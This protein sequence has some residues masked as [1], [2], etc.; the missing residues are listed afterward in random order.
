VNLIDA[1]FEAFVFVAILVI[2]TPGPDTALVMRNALR[3]GWWAASLTALGVGA[4][5]LIWAVA[6]T[7]GVGVLLQRSVIAF[8]VLKFAGAAYLVLLGIHSL[9]GSF[10]SGQTLAATAPPAERAQRPGSRTPFTQGVLNNLLN[11]KAGAIFVSILPQF[12][13][14]GDS[15]V[16]LVLMLL[17]YEAVLLLWLN[18]YGYLIGRAG[19]SRIGG[20]VRRVVERATGAV[21]IGLGARLAFER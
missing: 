14:P 11:P 12:V 6:S 4:G 13:R 5:S 15:P 8:T 3:A 10:R 20:R 18:V 17:V 1:R 16:R 9:I 21:L 19:R 7:A 2:V